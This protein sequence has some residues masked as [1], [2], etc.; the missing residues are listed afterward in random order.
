MQA[1]LECQNSKLLCICHCMQSRSLHV[2]KLLFFFLYT[3]EVCAHTTAAYIIIRMSL[4]QWFD[5]FQLAY[6]RICDIDALRVS[7]QTLCWNSSTG[8]YSYNIANR[9]MWQMS[10]R[11]SSNAAHR[12]FKVSFTFHYTD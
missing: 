11:K 12:G 10:F 8:K 5:N 3:L 2:R 7:A 1:L 9:T 6:H 4:N